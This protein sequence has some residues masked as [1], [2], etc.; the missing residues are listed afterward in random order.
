MKQ[1][2]VYILCL[3]FSGCQ[4]QTGNPAAGRASGNVISGSDSALV[5][6]FAALDS[7]KLDP[8]R[9]LSIVHIGDSHLQADYFSGM[10]RVLLQ[11]KFGNAGRGLVFPY[12]VARTNEPASYSSA[13]SGEWRGVRSVINPDSAAIGISGISLFSI[14]PQAGFSI[15]TK[16]QNNMSYAFK[17]V[18][19]FSQA[20]NPGNTLLFADRG[21][22][23]NAQKSS[24]CLSVYDLSDTSSRVTIR[25]SAGVD[26]H[27]LVLSNG[28]G[29]ILYH[30]IGVNGATFQ[31]YNSANL[32]LQQLPELN[33]DLLIV[34]LGT[35]ESYAGKFDV[36]GFEVQLGVFIEAVRKQCPSSSIL[37]TT[38]ADNCRVKKGK[39]L[40]NAR[41]PLIGN[42]LKSYASRHAC[43][44]WDLYEVMGGRGAMAQWKKQGLATAD[45][46]HFTRKGYE[47]QGRLLFEAL[48]NSSVQKP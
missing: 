24:A 33:P 21:M 34:S 15:R 38:P 30:T 16:P 17:R 18:T 20:A 12:T 39:P 11:E 4:A 31:S 2:S 1:F 8:S 27:G 47:R 44:V 28:R 43:A 42:L 23:V 29:G 9:T 36:D 6:F 35:N 48:M 32:F 19:L 22:T 14:S 10:L 46:V 37:L 3:L 26:V 25:F 41:V 13:S 5:H 45:Y 7:L 40:S